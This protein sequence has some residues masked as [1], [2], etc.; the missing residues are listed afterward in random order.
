VNKTQLAVHW[1]TAYL[2]HGEP[3]E[4]STLYADG[5]RAGYAKSTLVRARHRLPTGMR[6][7]TPRSG[8]QGNT[9]WTLVQVA[10]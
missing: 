6:I 4:S 2:A 8:F 3:V 10:Q 7:D 5:L 1:L 9:M